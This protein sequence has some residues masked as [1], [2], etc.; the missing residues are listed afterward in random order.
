MFRRHGY[1]IGLF[2]GK[3][4]QYHQGETKAGIEIKCDMRL[5]KTG[6]VYIEYQERMTNA[7][8]WV[9]SGILKQDQTKYF[10]IGTVEEFFILPRETAKLLS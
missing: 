5:Q 8:E 1:D 9:D 10:L 7:G 2:Y 6:N 3:D 4:Q